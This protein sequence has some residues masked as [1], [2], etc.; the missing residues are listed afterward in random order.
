MCRIDYRISWQIFLAFL[1]VAFLTACG[2]TYMHNP[3]NPDADWERD[4]AQ[5][6]AYA[7]ANSPG[8]IYLAQSTP[9][10]ASG[11]VGMT[12]YFYNNY[13][14][15]APTALQTDIANLNNSLG[16]LILRDRLYE[17]C[18]K[19]L[20]W[21][22][23]P[24]E[25]SEK[26]DSSA[27]ARNNQYKLCLEEKAAGMSS[28]YPSFEELKPAIENIC[29]ERTGGFIKGLSAYYARQAIDIKDQISK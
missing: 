1:L 7:L 2:K 29:R 10:G 20:G 8:P 16:V 17:L 24:K 27:V 18:L 6:D 23:A 26:P 14:N 21:V 3:G 11:L 9:L 25:E 12:P 13:N 19:Q 22:E 4:S 15:G 28:E 5:C